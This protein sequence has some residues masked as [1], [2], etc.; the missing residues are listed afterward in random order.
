MEAKTAG[1]GPYA[2]D[3]SEVLLE[4]PTGRGG[5]LLRS[6]WPIQHHRRR[7]ARRTPDS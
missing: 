2:Q 3:A 1:S 6:R 5:L 7:R 4:L